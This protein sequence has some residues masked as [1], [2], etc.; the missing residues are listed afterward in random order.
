MRTYRKRE[1]DPGDIRRLLEPG[2]VILV[3][4]AWKGVPNVMTMG[5][6]MMMGDGPV[7][8]GTYI[9]DQDY[10]RDIV[11][12]TKECVINI[13]TVELLETAIRIG[14]STGAEIDKFE[15]FGLTAGKA[16]KVKAPLI[17]E[18]YAS[19][20]CKLFDKTLARKRSLFIWKVVK[21]HVAASPKYPRTF[22]YRGDGVFMLSGTNVSR[23]RLFDPGM[24]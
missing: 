1:V 21:G 3:S 24:L 2:P 13:P 7:L 10:T 23:R 16:S 12:K 19:F 20:E 15:A 8:V 9:W 5:W 22:H 6:H 11:T 18:C 4:T 17:R 14:N